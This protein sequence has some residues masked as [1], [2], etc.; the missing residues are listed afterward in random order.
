MTTEYEIGDSI[1]G[2][3]EM[4]EYGA[5]I[6][7]LAPGSELLG[8]TVLPDGVMFCA[9]RIPVTGT[10]RGNDPIN[11]RGTPDA[12]ES[13]TLRN[14]YPYQ[15]WGAT[16]PGVG[17]DRTF[18]ARSDD[19][20]ENWYVIQDLGFTH[21]ATMDGVQIGYFV[22]AQIHR[23]KFRVRGEQDWNHSWGEQVPG[24][25]DQPD[26][27]VAVYPN[28]NDFMTGATLEEFLSF[29][30]TMRGVE[31]L[32]PSEMTSPWSINTVSENGQP[33]PTQGDDGEYY[34]IVGNS[35]QD[36]T[37]LRGP[38]YS[39]ST[40]RVYDVEDQWVSNEGRVDF[41]DPSIVYNY[42]DKNLSA[43]ITSH[44]T[45][46]VSGSNTIRTVAN[47]NR[48]D[49]DMNYLPGG[50][51]PIKFSASGVNRNGNFYLAGIGKVLEAGTLLLR[52]HA[53]FQAERVVDSNGNL[54]WRTQTWEI[55]HWYHFVSYDGFYSEGGQGTSWQGVTAVE[56]PQGFL[57]LS[58]TFWT[59]GV[60][61]GLRYYNNVLDSHFTWIEGGGFAP[62]NTM[63]GFNPRLTEKSTI[64]L[65]SSEPLDNIALG[66][67]EVG[68]MAV[69]VLYV[70]YLGN[71][72]VGVAGSRETKNYGRPGTRAI[73]SIRAGYSPTSPATSRRPGSLM[74]P[75]DDKNRYPLKIVAQSEG[76]KGFM[77]VFDPDVLD[78]FHKQ[79]DD[80]SIY[81]YAPQEGKQE[82][83]T[84]RK[85]TYW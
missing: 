13:N 30:P 80:D 31:T 59:D 48:Q 29:N 35:A 42:E 82:R 28:P 77:E 34:Y 15:Y 38:W 78:G 11:F 83:P 51:S 20:G 70:D 54:T 64:K 49:T 60:R 1:L 55:P 76:N 75:L 25:T 27:L 43:I 74:L 14:N 22:P 56:R 53:V 10:H 9:F 24:K 67:T 46:T 45:S 72:N 52:H 12:Y 7:I 40:Y 44:S 84:L 85:A 63:T 36:G 16:P 23:R 41:S 71:V 5:R 57:V 8:M 47:L 58:R 62:E 50:V 61:T 65:A 68:G 79:A 18:V 6:R 21:K 69:M 3:E 37:F 32:D 81:E 73:R 33:I 4:A 2:S 26:E 66:G 17:T 39:T 19:M